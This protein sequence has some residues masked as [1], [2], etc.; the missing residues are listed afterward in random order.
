[1]SETLTLNLWSRLEWGRCQ[2]LPSLTQL[3]A[4][5]LRNPSLWYVVPMVTQ[6]MEPLT[7]HHHW[8]LWWTNV[9]W[10]SGLSCDMFFVVL[11]WK[12]NLHFGVM[13]VYEILLDCSH[14]MS[15]LFKSR[16]SLPSCLNFD[17]KIMIYDQNMSSALGKNMYTVLSFSDK[18]IQQYPQDR[19]S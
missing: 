6:A 9:N 14:D 5:L 10:K 8:D 17:L 3:H 18:G 15:I 2:T 13:N 7:K 16:S 12:R 19:F 11:K 1:M 4:R